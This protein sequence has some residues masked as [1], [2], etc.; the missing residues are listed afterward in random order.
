MATRAAYASP[1]SPLLAPPLLMPFQ[2]AEPV[3]GDIPY[4]EDEPPVICADGTRLPRPPVLQP[5]DIGPM[6]YLHQK[7]M[8]E[9]ASRTPPSRTPAGTPCYSCGPTLFPDSI[10]RHYNE[11]I[12]RRHFREAQ[13]AAMA[14]AL[15]KSH[16]EERR[17]KR[18]RNVARAR[19]LEIDTD[20]DDREVHTRFMF[21]ISSRKLNLYEPVKG[22]S[23]YYRLLHRDTAKP[24]YWRD[25][26]YSPVRPRPL[27]DQIRDR[28]DLIYFTAPAPPRPG[29]FEVVVE[30]SPPVKETATHCIS[31]KWLSRAVKR[32]CGRRRRCEA[33]REDEIRTF[34]PV[35]RWSFT[36]E[37][38]N[39][40]QLG[41]LKSDVTPLCTCSSDPLL[42]VKQRSSVL[43]V[44]KREADMLASLT[45]SV[46]STPTTA[47][48]TYSLF[49]P[50]KD[51]SRIPRLDGTTAPNLCQG[52]ERRVV[53]HS[54]MFEKK[55]PMVHTLYSKTWA[56]QSYGQVGEKRHRANERSGK[57]EDN[58]SSYGPSRGIPQ[59]STASLSTMFQRRRNLLL[60][61]T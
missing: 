23:E 6:Q 22:T 19:R 21:A 20:L 4:I 58:R 28:I 56:R 41:C 45:G 51:L 55:P 17:P 16:A 14:E 49:Q 15:A 12:A 35:T 48:R 13:A 32:V 54:V 50:A 3:S 26:C 57:F 34:A 2:L 5:G 44:A 33:S 61:D 59:L 39:G 10:E 24:I 53:G 1:T 27:I 8:A 60:H 7:A 29:V 9:A 42:S 37:N 40:V 11:A 31:L 30:E 52:P 25:D 46:E 18:W 38:E 36:N 47:L 43:T